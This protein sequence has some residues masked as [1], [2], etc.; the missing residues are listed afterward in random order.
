MHPATSLPGEQNYLINSKLMQNYIVETPVSIEGEVVVTQDNAG[1]PAIFTVSNAGAVFCVRP[2]PAS[3]TGWSQTPTGLQVLQTANGFGNIAAGVSGSGNLVVLTPNG[4]RLNYVEEDSAEG[5]WGT[6]QT[7]SSAS[8]FP[9]AYVKAR[10]VRG[11][12]YLLLFGYFVGYEGQPPRPPYDLSLCEWQGADTNLSVPSFSYQT[13]SFSAEIGFA[14]G[15]LVVYSIITP[16]IYTAYTTQYSADN[17]YWDKGSETKQNGA[18][19]LPYVVGANYYNVGHYAAG[20]GH[21]GTYRYEVPTGQS[22]NVVSVDDPTGAPLLAR[23]VGYT[24]VWDSGGRTDEKGALWS[25]NPPSNDYVTLGHVATR[26]YDVPSTNEIRCVRADMAGPGNAYSEVP[27]CVGGYPEACNGLIIWSSMGAKS[28]IKHVSV[29]R[30]VASDECLSSGDGTF[31]A[32][33]NFQ[34]PSGPWYCLLKERPLESVIVFGPADDPGATPTRLNVSSPYRLLAYSMVNTPQGTSEFFGILA[35]RKVYYLD[36][37]AG[38]WVCLD[39]EHTFTG[40][41]AGV[42]NAGLFEV[43]AVS[44]DGYLFSVT[45]NTSAPAGWGLML[46]LD[47][48]RFSWLG[49]NRDADGDVVCF[50]A[51]AFTNDQPTTGALYGFL[52]DPATTNW[53]SREVALQS[54]DNVVEVRTYSTEITVFDANG[55]IRPG[56]RFQVWSDST[57]AANINGQTY[58][59]DAGRPVSCTSNYSGKVKVIVTTTMLSTPF[60]IFSTELMR[61]GESISVEPNAGIQ[62]TLAQVTPAQLEENLGLGETDA[63]NIAPALRSAMSLLR[64]SPPAV[65]KYLSANPDRRGLYYRASDD[66]PLYNEIDLSAITKQSWR[67]DFS[68]G[69][70]VF[71]TLTPDDALT[72]PDDSSGPPPDARGFFDWL[73]DLGDLV[74]SVIRGVAK[75]A[76]ITVKAIAE[77]VQTAIEVVINSV[78]YV[79]SAT[80]KLVEQVFDIVACIFETVGA[81]FAK[82]FEWL[83]FIFNWPD[84]L[85]THEVINYAMLQCKEFVKAANSALRAM[86]SDG[87]AYARGT[88]QSSI[89][90]FITSILGQTTAGAGGT[91]ILQ[92]SQEY[93]KPSSTSQQIAGTNIVLDGFVDNA[94]AAQPAGGSFSERLQSSVTDPVSTLIGQMTQLGG[95]DGPIQTSTAFAEAFDYFKSIPAEP[96][97]LLQ[98]V[99][100]GL[101]KLLEGIATLCLNLAQSL[102][103]ALFDALNNALDALWGLLNEEWKI[104]FVSALYKKIAGNP[105]SM[106]DLMSL[107]VAVPATVVYKLVFNEAP[108][109]TPQD[110][111]AFKQAF[112]TQF[113]VQRS[114]LGAS[115]QSSLP[116]ATLPNTTAQFFG[117]V[118]AGCLMG[119]GVVE[120]LLDVIPLSSPTGPPDWMGL[121]AVALEFVLWVSACPWFNP[122]D[123]VGII[124]EGAYYAANAIWAGTGWLP[125]AFDGFAY[126]MPHDSKHHVILRNF[127]V[128]CLVVDWGLG[129][130]LT[131]L[132]CF[133]SSAAGWPVLPTVQGFL[134]NCPSLL[135][136][137]RI[138]PL[139]T[140]FTLGALGVADLVGDVSAAFLQFGLLPGEPGRHSH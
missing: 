111:D 70:P 39:A 95:D 138:P 84:I 83:G 58:L 73:D 129:I 65:S 114:G 81:T 108:F 43:F 45:Q 16:Q 9:I 110:V 128:G 13:D 8:D 126:L 54:T 44:T 115:G 107:I 63:A 118:Y 37:Q 79:Y 15:G 10:N 78:K 27:G 69:A 40:V 49:T 140:P 131:G 91:T 74:N 76:C 89:D 23:P 123:T 90:G 34:V 2:D 50:A 17:L 96:D 127:S 41:A 104:P 72:C 62:N 55:V 101:L 21:S 121:A 85:R 77:G 52:K 139:S 93:G 119:Y 133:Q 60:I 98:L 14:S 82:V 71:K 66:A 106:L 12:L 57:A 26:G 46:Q 136:I 112:N 68:S 18:F 51:T 124:G 24:K 97:K 80:L 48:A 94:D 99:A 33:G 25:P 30:V 7:L 116:A 134:S 120:L 35:D 38:T 19:W 88:V 130:V 53:E 20:S 87:I 92:L 22:L 109:P 56:T 103:N 75:V 122:D 28:G 3:K 6:P 36:Q 59:L 102:V 61:P 11:Q 64:K 137:V 117:S 1:R 67:L 100:A 4:A 132:F 135:K 105:L 125:F 29:D 32:H 47:T 42:N 5:I 31:F 86:A 113:L